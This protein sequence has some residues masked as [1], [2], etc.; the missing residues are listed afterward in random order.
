MSAGYVLAVTAFKWQDMIDKGNKNDE[1]VG[2]AIKTAL[3]FS[4]MYTGIVFSVVGITLLPIGLANMNDTTGPLLLKVAL[5]VG[6]NGLAL[7]MLTVMRC[8]KRLSYA[9]T[10]G[11]LPS[12]SAS[13]RRRRLC[14]RSSLL[15]LLAVRRVGKRRRRR[16]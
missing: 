2:G 16:M 8:W 7:V 10:V 15:G 4:N 9:S 3:T 5:A 12:E 6:I 11:V 1:T 13:H 14:S